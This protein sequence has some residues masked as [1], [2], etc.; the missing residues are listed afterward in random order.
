MS[1]IGGVTDS[2]TKTDFYS[3]YHESVTDVTRFWTTAMQTEIAR[4]NAGWQIGRI[5]FVEYLRK[6]DLRYWVAFNMLQKSGPFR[7]ICDVGGFWGA[8]PLT[9]RRLGLEVSMTE[10]LNYYSESFNPLFNYLIKEGVAVID[11]DPFE[12]DTERIAGKF[13]VVSAMAVLE[14][15]PH[16]QRKF[17]DFMRS[18]VEPDGR[19]YIEVPN[20]AYWP[21]RIALLCGKSPLAN[22]GDVFLSEK[23]FTGHHRE[24]TPADLQM[25]ASIGQFDV[26]DRIQFNYSFRGPWIKR[27]ISDPMLTLMSQIPA[28]RECTAVLL[29]PQ[30]IDRSDDV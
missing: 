28:M 5:D 29:K 11:T 12:D 22:I 1:E 8:Y 10:A 23:P 4:H 20:I 14:H 30:Q 25:L 2:I 21:R 16:S 9:L 26:V 7:S 15:Y 24:Y 6:S 19:L 13:D 27:F 18:M 17:L 3:A